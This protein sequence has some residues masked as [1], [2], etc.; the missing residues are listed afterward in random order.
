MSLDDLKNFRIVSETLNITRASEVL[1]LSQPALS[2]SIKRLESELGVELIVRLKNGIQLSKAGEEFLKK[3]NRLIIAWEDSQKILSDNSKEVRGEFSIGLHPSVALYCL[4]KFLLEIDREFPL[5]N[6]KISHGLSREM[7][8]KVINWELDFGIIINPTNHPDLV[9]TEVAKD[10]VSL[11]K[12]SRSKNK[13]IYDP[14]LA[15]SL[16]ILKKLNPTKYGLRG[17]IQT[18]N[19]EVV[20]KLA[21]AGLGIGL[22]PTRVANQYKGLREVKGSPTFR[23]RLCLVYRKEKHK[24]YVSKRI[25]NLL[26]QT[27]I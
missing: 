2:Y 7:V 26:K 24:N 21:S 27:E 9:I 17:E 19:L 10:T 16:F 25:I 14:A 23:D 13:L 11:F 15:Q 22:L 12:A 5:L 4:D 1:G 18:A 20:A 8:N 6:Y 3:V